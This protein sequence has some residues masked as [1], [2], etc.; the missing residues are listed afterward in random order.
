MLCFQKIMI[1]NGLH[2][3]SLWLKYIYYTIRRKVYLFGR[4][5]DNDNCVLIILIRSLY[6]RTKLWIDL[7]NKSA[8][9]FKGDF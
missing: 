4:T 3:E 9:Y 7:K 2:L 8:V 6:I 1:P 5:N